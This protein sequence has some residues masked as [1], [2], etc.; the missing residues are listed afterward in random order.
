MSVDRAATRSVVT[1]DDG[2]RIAVTRRGAGPPVVLVDGAL[3]SSRTDPDRPLAEHLAGA[4]TVYDYDRRGRGDSTDTPP[5]APRRE[6]EDLAAVVSAAGVGCHLFGV[7]AGAALALE[8]TAAGVPVRRLA[9]YEPPYTGEVVGSADVRRTRNELEALLDDEARGHARYGEAVAQLFTVSGMPKEMVT[10]LRCTPI[11][12]E[13]EA[14]APTIAYDLAVLDDGVVPR[15]R[16]ESIDVP[17]LVLDGAASPELLRRPARIVAC[18]ASAAA[19]QSLPDQTHDVAPEV[20]APVLAD[21][22]GSR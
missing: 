6:V 11:W 3:A 17:T 15:Q 9:V 5:Y 1:S 2:T 13:Y 4:F 19:Y 21:F 10:L 12:R 18:V 16:F 8:A 7:S 20:L 14:L 22:F